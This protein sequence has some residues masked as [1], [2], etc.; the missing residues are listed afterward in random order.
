MQTILNESGNNIWERIAPI[1]D[2]A[3]ASLNEKDRRA[4]VLRF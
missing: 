4:I 1:L 3:V 2:T